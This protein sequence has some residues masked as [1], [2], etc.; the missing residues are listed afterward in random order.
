LCTLEEAWS[1]Y[2][3]R[4]HIRMQASG[5]DDHR[6][7][8]LGEILQQHPGRIPVTLH[9]VIPGMGEVIYEVEQNFYVS[10]GPDLQESVEL[11]LE[12]ESV[13]FGKTSPGSNGGNGYGNGRNGGWRGRRN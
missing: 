5:M 10:P 11:L 8:S 3:A 9:I 1:Q 12:E 13:W 6:L 7:K 4:V 2:I